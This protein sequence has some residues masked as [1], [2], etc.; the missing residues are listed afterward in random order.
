M[1]T[2]LIT[3]AN[4]GVG[5]E[6]AKAYAARGDEVLASCRN[7]GQAE[8]L[9]AV[10][11]KVEVHELAVDS[12]ASVQAL[13]AKLGSRP[14]DLLINNAGISG[15]D[16]QQQT[17]LEMDFDG[18]LET[19]N[20]NTLGPVRVMQALIENLRAGSSPKQVTI[21]SQ[22]GALSLDLPA[23]YAY[24]ASKAAVNKFMRLAAIEL[25]KDGIAVGLI[26]PGWVR[27]D[28]GGARAE[29]SAEESAKGV[30]SVI[31]QLSMENSGGFWKWDGDVHD[32]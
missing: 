5:L 20:V 4:R 17:A 3:G 18:W 31:D 15:P 28:M 10:T 16:R 23:A 1:A 26:H 32:W 30:V 9:Q 29:I 11:G 6:L 14:V 24:C 22:L 8:Q 19:F 21:T 7:P 27:T 25:Q 13:A 12:D 2:V